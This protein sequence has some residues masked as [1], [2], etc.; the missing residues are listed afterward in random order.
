M[1]TYSSFLHCHSYTAASEA[2]I[3]IIIFLIMSYIIIFRLDA[4]VEIIILKKRSQYVPGTVV[5]L[6]WVG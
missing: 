1:R 3:N 6:E 4:M 5:G 2:I